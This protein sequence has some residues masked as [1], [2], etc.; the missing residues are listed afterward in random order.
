MNR[1]RIGFLTLILAALVVT[2]VF[3]PSGT[4]SAQ[5]EIEKT[6]WATTMIYPVG[7]PLDFQRPGPGELRGFQLSRGVK[8]HRRGRHE[9][10]DLANKGQGSQVRAVA[11][12]LV[13][14]TRTGHAGGWGNMVVLAHRLPGGDVLFSLFAHLMPGS[15]AVRE[16]EIVALGQPLGR[17][18]QT[19]HARGPHLHLEFRTLKGSLD[20]LS[21]PLARAWE[22]ASIVDPFRIFAAMLPRSGDI[23]LPPA[24]SLDP[25]RELVGRG[26]FAPTALERGDEAL[27]RG[28]LYRIALASLTDPGQAVPRRWAS[29]RERLISRARKAPSPARE[30]FTAVR[31]PRRESDA[32]RPAGLTETIEVLRALEGAGVT[33]PSTGRDGLVAAFPH[34]LPALDPSTL[35]VSAGPLPRGFVGPPAVSR[36]QAGLLWAYLSA[37]GTTGTGASTGVPGSAV[38]TVVAPSSPSRE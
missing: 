21:D 29:V 38:G 14:C 34:A 26:A 32:A 13:V 16:G 9:G 3:A 10:L 18:G 11:P 25:L 2:G 6:P 17:I 36:R 37:G 7:D 27:T 28:E 30:A 33:V 5:G 22:G 4:A 12:G 19:G 23:L 31:L 24:P 15:I 35:I 1:P 20:R 8:L